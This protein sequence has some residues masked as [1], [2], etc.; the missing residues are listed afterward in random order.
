MPPSERCGNRRRDRRARASASAGRRR[1]EAPS[2]LLIAARTASRSRVGVRRD[3]RRPPLRRGRRAARRPRRRS[4]TRTSSSRSSGVPMAL[5]ASPGTDEG[6]ELRGRILEHEPCRSPS[7][8]RAARRRPRAAVTRPPTR[9][10]GPSVCGEVAS[11]T[12]RSSG[13]WRDRGRC[14]RPR[15]AVP[16]P[17]AAACGLAVAPAA[18]DAAGAGR[19]RGRRSTRARPRTAGRWPSGRDA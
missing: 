19:G 17:G 9:T 11:A 16:L 7:R 5:S 4:T 8:R 13:P 6:R 2:P 12:S 3:G 10:R 14:A 1:V 15:A 18:P